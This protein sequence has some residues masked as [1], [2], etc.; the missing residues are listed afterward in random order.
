ME[1][2]IRGH[3]AMHWRNA[4]TT[5][6]SVPRHRATLVVGIAVTLAA[7]LC[8]HSAQGGLIVKRQAVSGEE[9]ASLPT[10][11]ATAI[12]EREE[13]STEPAPTTRTIQWCA[14][15]GFQNTSR[16]GSEPTEPKLTLM[17]KFSKPP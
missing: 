4:Q 13:T 8:A 5:M 3:R 17:Q 9:L 2:G 14:T 12:D 16:I 7:L 1:S 11:V 6:A 10:T 15:R